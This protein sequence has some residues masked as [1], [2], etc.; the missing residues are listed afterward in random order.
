MAQQKRIKIGAIRFQVWSLAL[1]S[2]LRIWRFSELWCRLA[3]VALIRPLAWK[4]PCAAGEALKKKKENTNWEILKYWWWLSIQ[5]GPGFRHK[6]KW[7]LFISFEIAVFIANL[8]LTARFYPVHTGHIF[9]KVFI[10]DTNEFHILYKV[11][12]NGIKTLD[13][14]SLSH[15]VSL[16]L[17]LFS[18][19]FY[20]YTSILDWDSLRYTLI[21]LPY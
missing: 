5:S 17:E 19:Q 18:L 6:S 3:A 9:N 20:K 1:L 11:F 4:L 15:W 13:G 10:S 16:K 2:G 12:I 14:S 21:L 8:L 7:K